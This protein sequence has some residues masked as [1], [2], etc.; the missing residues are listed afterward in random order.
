VASDRRICP[1]CG[2]PIWEDATEDERIAE[3]PRICSPLRCKAWTVIGRATPP[4]PITGART[5]LRLVDT[6]SRRG[7]GGDA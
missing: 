5:M 1:R 4:H 3:P 7:G 6:T 2:H